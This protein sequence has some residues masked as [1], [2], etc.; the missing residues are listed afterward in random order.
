[1]LWNG[2]ECGENKIM[3][4]SNNEKP[5]CK[6]WGQNLLQNVEY[7]DYFGSMVTN[8][9]GCTWEIK[10]K[11]AMAKAAF[12]KKKKKNSF[13]QQIGLNLSKKLVKCHILCIA[14]YCVER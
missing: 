5:Q 11:S 2:K 1:M 9:T 3:R 6:M 7:F 13:R 4:I 8:D 10:S 14:S 12:S